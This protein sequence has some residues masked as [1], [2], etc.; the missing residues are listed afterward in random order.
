MSTDPFYTRMSADT[1]G[2]TNLARG[3]TALISSDNLG[4]GVY[5]NAA[6]ATDGYSNANWANPD[7]TLTN[8]ITHSLLDPMSSLNSTY[9]G[10]WLSNNG[11]ISTAYG[12]LT[13]IGQNVFAIGNFGGTYQYSW[14][15]GQWLALS[16]DTPGGRT[17][18]SMGANNVLWG[19]APDS[20]CSAPNWGPWTCSSGGYFQ[21]AAGNGNNP[22]VI[23]IPKTGIYRRDNNG[24]WVLMLAANWPNRTT[25][26]TL[27]QIAVGADED[28]WA[29]DST[30]EVIHWVG[31]VGWIQEQPYFA[32]VPVQVNA[33]SLRNAKYVWA[34]ASS[35]TGLF[36]FTP[37]WHDA[38]TDQQR[39]WQHHCPTAGCST[40]TSQFVAVSVGLQDNSVY[41]VTSSATGGQVYQVDESLVLNRNLAGSTDLSL[42]NL[43]NPPGT[44]FAQVAALGGANGQQHGNIFATATN[45]AG[46]TNYNYA[47]K[48]PFPGAAWWYVDLGSTYH[49]EK[50]KIYNRDDGYASRLQNFRI[51][52]YTGLAW[53]L[54][55]DQTDNPMTSSDLSLSIDVNFDTRYVM[56][57][58]GNSD[59]LSLA[60]VEIYGPS[61]GVS[62]FS[63]IGGTNSA[64]QTPSGDPT[65]PS[66]TIPLPRPETSPLCLKMAPDDIVVKDRKG[67]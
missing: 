53:S 10:Q 7:G 41:A 20:V 61:A 29:I 23:D 52:Y 47:G 49:I 57:Q 55:S 4:I 64:L 15:S 66:I 34:S 50:I 58:K 19:V 54:G 31:G 62:Q 8:T 67:N 65:C 51:L 11:G 40:S 14:S 38:Q 44:A 45:G 42:V 25:G 2:S 1:I 35:T 60:E 12:A 63:A 33:I 39:R 5:A 28:A 22:W 17:Q 56:V 18:I 3:M 27:K 26:A 6:R 24:A 16:G 48:L 21:I 36:N 59:Y 13:G 46:F 37:S 9:G 43:P 30:G 32:G